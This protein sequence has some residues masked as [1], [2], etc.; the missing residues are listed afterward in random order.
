[1]QKTP[2]A[3][4]EPAAPAIVLPP[5]MRRTSFADWYERVYPSLSGSGLWLNGDEPGRIEPEAFDACDYRILFARLS[6]WSDTVESFT[7]RLLYQVARS[8]AGVYPDYAFLPP[9]TDLP[10][11]AKDGVPWL[12]GIHS[13][14]G[15]AA[16]DAIG[17]SNSIV[18][19][20]INL[21]AMLEAS[22]IPVGKKERMARPDVPLILL[23]GANAIHT[24][25][26]MVPNPPVDIIF[27]GESVD[28]IRDIFRRMADGKRR[29][30]SKLQILDQLEEI[31]GCILPDRPRATS[32]AHAALPG[33]SALMIGAPQPL[34][35]DTAG[36]GV[37]QISEGCRSFCSFC[38]ESYV[39]KPYREEKL[40]VLLR[41]ARELKKSGGLQKLDF[42]SFNF[43]SYGDFFPLVEGLT[44][45]YAQIG[46]KSQR[47]DTVADDARLLPL[48]HVLGKSSLTFGIEG[49]SERLRGYLNKGID[50][51]TI[52]RGMD[53]VV[54][55][56]VREVKLFFILTG[57]ETDDDFDELR[58]LAT[59]LKS[60]IAR[61]GR[62]P[63]LVFSATPLVRFPWTPL[64]WEPAPTIRDVEKLATRFEK[65]VAVE[66]F[67]A[68][69]A[70][71]A[72]ESW[73]SQIIARA[74]H[75]SVYEAL[76]LA[77]KKTGYLYYMHVTGKFANALKSE[78]VTAGL[79]PDA[80]AAPLAMDDDSAPWVMLGSGLKRD[81]LKH[82][83]L[84]ART[85]AEVV[86][87]KQAQP[88]IARTPITGA[89][90]A[91]L[92][93]RLALML[94]ERRKALASVPV[95]V[96]LLS[97]MKNVPRALAGSLLA[98]ALMRSWDD[99]VPHY[100]GYKGTLRTGDLEFAA[101]T[102][103]DVISLA[104]THE[105]GELLRAHL[106]EP[107][108]VAL[109]N[110]ML[111]PRM[112]LDADPLA[113]AP[114]LVALELCAPLRF[115]G[116][117]YCVANHL[118]FTLRKPSPGLSVYDFTPQSLKK[119]PLRSLTTKTRDDGTVVVSIVARLDF[120]I[121]GFIKGAYELLE[122]GDWARVDVVASDKRG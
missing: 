44:G 23:G 109:V 69:A 112:E 26:L 62:G 115:I 19:E 76:R 101:V 59:A 80:C 25:L 86:R 60:L 79:D 57:L 68:R 65:I 87:E 17:I 110:G 47:M 41:D 95:R 9:W 96:N 20:L 121:M 34:S 73:V 75:S 30:L 58:S 27:A 78:L 93:E 42:F 32:K 36:A 40:A 118:K 103:L 85:H 98:S 67:E 72:E 45:M 33:T 64:E 7:H 71:P 12:L 116:Q 14:R 84:E 37:I 13:K 83:A 61:A 91:K 56:P 54:R 52:T 88:G 29:G 99:L 119:S 66:G 48:L 31:E 74:R 122:P 111:A 3:S 50:L 4:T 46:L 51:A 106:A 22:G 1:M 107:G 15:A 97:R 35:E 113:A 28:L 8:V 39:R 16:F 38:S 77:Q 89:G 120:D 49:I 63:R 117:D 21:P 70:A 104:W 18:Q 105:G 5:D 92:H 10:V 53:A 2:P 55:A 43:A 114:E 11:F 6:T 108:A 102:G 94:D 82:K 100:M 90:A 24:S 81:F